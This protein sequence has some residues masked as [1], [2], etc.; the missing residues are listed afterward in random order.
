MV[1]QLA[2]PPQRPWLAAAGLLLGCC[3]LQHAASGSRGAAGAPALVW[4]EDAGVWGQDGGSGPLRRQLQARNGS[5]SDEWAPSWLPYG[6]AAAAEEV[7]G[8]DG[9][10]L[11]SLHSANASEALAGLVFE[12]GSVNAPVWLGLVW[13]NVTSGWRWNDQSEL[14]YWAGREG[15]GWS[16]PAPLADGSGCVVGT[17]T[18]ESALRWDVVSCDTR[19]RYVCGGVLEIDSSGSWS[20][21]LDLFSSRVSLDSCITADGDSNPLS[22]LCPAEDLVL[23][24]D[25]PPPPELGPEDEGAV[26]VVTTEHGLAAFQRLCDDPEDESRFQVCTNS[27]L[28]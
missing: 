5:I 28:W 25:G 8:R 3:G 27:P 12:E 23:F 16:A 1:A 11:I 20:S 14:D 26:E 24:V 22:L 9:R 15:A 18:S 7:C 10:S 21:E 4:V 13:S 6:A 19:N 17:A 2:R